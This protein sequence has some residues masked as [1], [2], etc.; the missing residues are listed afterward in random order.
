MNQLHAKALRSFSIKLKSFFLLRA[1]LRAA[2]AWLF[3]WGVVILVIRISG[4]S[5]SMQL[6]V[7]MFGVVPVGLLSAWQARKALPRFEKIRANYDQLNNCGGLVMSEEA[8]D[9]SAWQSRLSDCASPKVQWHGNKALAGLLIAAGFALVTLLI[10]A[11]LVRIPGRQPLEVRQIAEQLQTEMQALHQEKILDDKKA[12]DLQKQL[13]QIEENS[14]GYDPDKTWEAL[15]H[16][17]QSDS[18]AAK[19]AAQEALAKTEAMSQAETVAQAMQQAADNG[20][21]DATASQAAQDLAQML[22]DAKLEDGVLD[23]QL[24]ADS[25]AGPNGLNQEQLQ[26]LLNSLKDHKSSLSKTMRHLDQLKL[27]DTSMLSECMKDGECNNP[28]ALAAYLANCKGQCDMS[29]LLACSRPGK[30]GP[31]GGGPEAPMTWSE[32]TSEK[33]LKFKEH[34]L[35]AAASLSD[36]QLVGVSRSA[37][38]VNHSAAPV[39]SGGLAGAAGS[40]GSA[41]AQVILPEQRQVVRNFFHRDGQ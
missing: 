15:D 14:S 37:P 4:V 2:A 17:K 23:T 9:M 21:S 3:I 29:M 1:C 8:G 40:G 38:Q 26:K 11:R 5:Q 24:P 16:I 39:Q 18:D 34:A 13:S 20:M 22:S 41:N 25:L 10:P 31:G 35:P 19:Q 28:D 6:A 33:D 7:G 30:G 12:D 32:G 27:I 36:A